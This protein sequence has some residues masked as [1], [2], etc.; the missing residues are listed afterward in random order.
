MC[1]LAEAVCVVGF[2]VEDRR[3]FGCSPTH[4]WSVA[5]AGLRI[6]VFG[7]MEMLQQFRPPFPGSL[8]LIGDMGQSG[9]HASGSSQHELLTGGISIVAYCRGPQQLPV[10]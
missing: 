10:L 6:Q 1:A 7:W 5:E 9:L 4:L 3:R 2:A 8:S